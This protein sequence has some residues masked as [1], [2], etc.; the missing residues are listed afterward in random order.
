MISYQS[1]GVEMPGLDYAVLG[2]WLSAVVGSYDRII[3]NVCY[4]FCGDEEILNANRQFLNH[5]Y[6]TDIITFDYT[7]GNKIGGDIMISLDTVASNAEDLSVS[8]ESELFR[9]I[10][11]G[12]LHL[13]GLKD[14]SP[15]ERSK[16]E[17]A[18]NKA[19]AL[20]NEI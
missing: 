19:L 17:C 6:Y 3:G 14:K 15:E 4:L 12:I 7:V 10:V 18:E 13:C 5:D 20:L 16:M 9:V 1:Q 2:R 11:H 8:Y